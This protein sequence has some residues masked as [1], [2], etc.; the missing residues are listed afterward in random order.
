MKFKTLFIL[1]FIWSGWANP[2]FAAFPSKTALVA[3]KHSTKQTGFYKK[4]YFNY[5]FDGT[6]PHKSKAIALLLSCPFF[7]LSIFGLHDF[8]LGRKEEGNTHLFLVILA[9][10]LAFV[11]TLSV[12]P[13]ISIFSLSISIFSLAAIGLFAINGI[14]AGIEFF[15]ILFNLLLPISG[16]WG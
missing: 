5:H 8:Y 11:G 7:Y 4:H 14:W 9:G 13:V 10:V 16:H 1:L 6:Q 2:C 12:N 3:D 15:E